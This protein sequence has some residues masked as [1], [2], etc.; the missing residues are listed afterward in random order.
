VDFPDVR[1]IFVAVENTAR[2]HALKAGAEAFFLKD[3][4]FNELM[5]M[6]RETAWPA[7]LRHLSEMSDERGLPRRT[8]KRV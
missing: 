5:A 3:Q 7:K 8:P 2:S 6:L 1:I 4:G